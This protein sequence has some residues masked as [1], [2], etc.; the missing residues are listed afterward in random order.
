MPNGSSDTVCNSSGNETFQEVVQTRLSRRDFIGGSLAAAATASLAGGVGSLLSAVPLS[1][2]S[3]HHFPLLGFQGIPVSSADTV[4][5]PPGYTAKVLIAWGDPVSNGP[6]FKPDASN[7]AAEQAL[8]WGMHNDG[9]VYFPID[10]SRH[11]LLVQ[12]N[13]Y[14]DDVPAVYRWH[15][16][17]ESGKNQ[18]VAQ[19]PRRLCHRDHPEEPPTAIT[20]WRRW[21]A[22]GRRATKRMASCPPID[23]CAT[24]HRH[25]ADPDWR[26]AGAAGEP[27]PI[28]LDYQRRSDRS[29]GARH[30]QQLRHGIYALGHLPGM[31][32]ELQRLLPKERDADRLGAPL[33][34]QRRGGGLPLAHDR[35]AVQRRRRT[36]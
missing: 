4:E 21:E 27:L 11:G 3:W 2:K 14:T 30:D 32:R 9:V 15:R 18:Q 13:E 29:P 1:A 28:R 10:G 12:N 5:V 6:A 17:L 16:E 22:D 33:R 20:G 24:H 25:D 34:H 8:Q 35:Q 31:R 36:Q 7:T 26:T 19:R 23:L